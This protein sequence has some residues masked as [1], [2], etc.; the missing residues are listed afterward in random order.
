[1]AEAIQDFCGPLTEKE[2]I[3]ALKRN[4]PLEHRTVQKACRELQETIAFEKDCLEKA[5]KLYTAYFKDVQINLEGNPLH[6]RAQARELLN[7]ALKRWRFQS[8]DAVLTL[9]IALEKA[10]MEGVETHFFKIEV[11]RLTEK[12]GPLMSVFEHTMK[13]GVNTFSPQ[14]GWF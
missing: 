7:E 4:P 11:R 9:A 6:Q 12:R 3:R 5:E 14:L 1:L 2:A 13:A 8:K 10:K